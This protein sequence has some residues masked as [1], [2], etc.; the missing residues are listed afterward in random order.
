VKKFLLIFFFFGV[1]ICSAQYMDTLHEVFKNKS[2]IDARLESR[3]TFIDNQLAN[4]TGFRLGVAFQR[5]LRL[6]GGVSWLKSDFTRVF[7]DDPSV[8]T[9][10]THLKYLKFGY[11]CF[12]ADFVFYK[13][14]RWQLSV[15]ILG[16][17]G[18]IW[19]QKKITYDLQS[20]GR[21]YFL[22]L[23]EP[24]ISVQFKVFRWL[25]AGSDIGYRFVAKDNKKISE[26]LYSPTYSFKILIWFDQLF[27]ELFPK[28]KITEK[29]G[30]AQW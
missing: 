27:F 28:T 2:S 18:L 11:L 16:G 30:P 21:K 10:P 8:L 26:Q 23:Y 12:Y 22:G 6:G 20:P 14:K 1:T 7:A 19:Y 9:S 4:I 15:P 3:Y 17:L 29:Y 5:K 25:G 13:T 24:G